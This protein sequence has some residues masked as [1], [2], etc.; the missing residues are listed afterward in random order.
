MVVD[1]I[2]VCRVMSEKLWVLCYEE[3]FYELVEGEQICLEGGGCD[4]VVGLCLDFLELVIKFD[5]L[6]FERRNGQ[7]VV[8]YYMLFFLSCCV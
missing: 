2:Q 7:G 6:E 3:G 1:V 4:Y 5:F 8:S